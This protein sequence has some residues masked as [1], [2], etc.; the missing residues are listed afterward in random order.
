MGVLHLANK[1]D[2]LRRGFD[3]VDIAK[4]ELG[5]AKLAHALLSIERLSYAHTSQVLEGCFKALLRLC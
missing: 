3:D 4:V 2:A 1:A 5:A